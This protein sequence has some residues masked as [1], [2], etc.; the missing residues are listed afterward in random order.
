MFDYEIRSFTLS[1]YKDFR[2]ATNQLVLVDAIRM[3]A[4]KRPTRKPQRRSIRPESAGAAAASPKR[5]R[6]PSRRPVRRPSSATPP[7]K[8]G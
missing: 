2:I 6:P 8:L 7:F 5:R 3:G 1:K 4:P